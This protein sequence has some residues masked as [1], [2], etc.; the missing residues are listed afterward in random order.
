VDATKL[1]EASNGFAGRIAAEHDAGWGA[2]SPFILTNQSWGGDVMS[3][4]SLKAFVLDLEDSFEIS[5]LK[6]TD[7]R[8]QRRLPDSAGT[9]EALAKFRDIA[10]LDIS[11]H[12]FSDMESKAEKTALLKSTAIS[13]FTIAS[14]HAAPLKF[15]LGELSVFRLSTKG[16]R[17]VAAVKASDVLDF[18]SNADV[19]NA[20]KTL[21]AAATWM[22]L[23]NADKVQEFVGAGFKVF[24]AT[25]GP[26]DVLYTPA[27]FLTAHKVMNSS[28]VLGL[29][30]GCLG[31]S[32]MDL[33]AI[34]GL[35]DSH[36]SAGKV[37]AILE[38][39][40]AVLEGYDK[41]MQAMPPAAL[42][43]SAGG[44]ADAV[45]SFDNAVQSDEEAGL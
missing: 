39:A 22:S 25:V 18:C 20:P 9:A 42:A 24:I 12:D 30:V 3:T 21:H 33:P 40:V 10:P 43:A 6:T 1:P 44:S 23:A 4:E 32:G 41:Q 27:G 16:M 29:R 5:A 17:V 2:A 35:L 11:V 36:K 8:A 26:G 7:G 14:G 13:L 28:N 19:A 34:Q 45:D 15:E 31:L 37:S 38:Q